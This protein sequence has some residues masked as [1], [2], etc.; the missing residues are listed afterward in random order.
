MWTQMKLLLKEQ[1]YLN[2]QAHCLTKMFLTHYISVDDIAD[3]FCWEC[4]FGDI[5][6]ILGRIVPK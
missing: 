3:K 2:V 5:S 6:S 4:R 1:P